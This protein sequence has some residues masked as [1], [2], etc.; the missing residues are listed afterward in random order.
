[1]KEEEEGVVTLSV[2]WSLSAGS[3]KLLQML[4]FT[5]YGNNSVSDVLAS[6]G[7]N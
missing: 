2:C 7:Y 1:M 6:K 3:Y 5:S 4:M